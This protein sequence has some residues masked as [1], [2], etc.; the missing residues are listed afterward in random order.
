VSSQAIVEYYRCP[1]ELL[2]F[3][4]ADSLKESC[5]YFRFGPDLVCY[6]QTS[7]YPYPIVN[8]SLFDA[9]EPVRRHEHIS[10]LPF[11]LTQVVDN[12]R[13]ERYVDQAGQPRDLKSKWIKKVYYLLRPL[14]PISLR[15]HLQQFSLRGWETIPF[16]AWP[17]DRSVDRLFEK[18]LRITLQ[19]WR[20]DRLPFIWF[21]PEGHTACAIVT[22]D[23]EALSGRDFTGRLMDI[24]DAYGIKASFQVI[25]E[26]RYTISQEYLDALRERDFEIGIHGLTHDGRLFWNLEE[27]LRRAKK[28]NQYAKE[29]G[30]QGFRSPV[31]Y[32]NVDWMKHLRFS[33]DMSVPNVA[34]LDPQRGGCC[35]IMPYFLPDGMLELPLTTIQDYSLFYIL[36]E[37]SIALWQKQISIIL[38]GHGLMSFNIH[39]DYVMQNRAQ[40]VYK[41]LLEYLSQLRADYGVWVALPREVN[42]WWRERSEMR[43]VSE[44]GGWRIEG[45]GS[46]RAR[47][48]YAQLDGDQLVYEID[49]SWNGL[50]NESH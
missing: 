2:N 18:L 39:P 12:L 19:A 24:D 43:L 50:R 42:R 33:Y 34:H 15:K 36:E 26:Q 10:F 20:I 1:E 7:G 35:T 40:D 5:G 49:S 16:P 17:V 21:W 8:G 23:V 47:L 45:P 30:A 31:M 13:Y 11:H 48:A 3:H 22:H 37:Y 9:S 6:G 38:G 44:G 41:A 25:P 46:S 28:I 29:F 27:F 4:V 14:L 32:R